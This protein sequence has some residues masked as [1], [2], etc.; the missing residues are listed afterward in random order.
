M[1]KTKINL[2][3]EVSTQFGPKNAVDLIGVLLNVP[4]VNHITVKKVETD[5]KVKTAEDCNKFF[6]GNG[7]IKLK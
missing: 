5:Y 4:A 6:I 3:V 7:E 1:Y 2:E